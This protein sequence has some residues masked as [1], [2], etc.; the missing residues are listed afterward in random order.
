[1]NNANEPHENTAATD[2]EIIR[3]MRRELDIVNEMRAVDLLLRFN[4]ILDA[5]AQGH[6]RF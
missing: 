4:V 2:R 3:E 1:M 6:E 5:E